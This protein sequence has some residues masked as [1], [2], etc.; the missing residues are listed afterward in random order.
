LHLSG[1][2]PILPNSDKEEDGDQQMD[3][4]DLRDY[5][6]QDIAPP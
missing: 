6:E 4:D 1:A 3:A 5:S 2:L